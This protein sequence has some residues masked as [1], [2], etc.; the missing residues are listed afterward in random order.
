MPPSA[1]PSSS[2]SALATSSSSDWPSEA[3]LTSKT[4]ALFPNI[5]SN[6]NKTAFVDAAIRLDDILVF[7]GLESLGTL[8]I[9]GNLCLIVVLLRNKYLHRAS[10]ILMLSLAIADV[11]HGIVTTSFFYPPIILKSIPIPPL[12]I[13][14]FNIVDWTAWSITLT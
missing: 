14:I 5:I 4:H 6:N 9:T 1:E 13:R 10:F 3:H 12:G 2:S 8:A 11:L 7:V